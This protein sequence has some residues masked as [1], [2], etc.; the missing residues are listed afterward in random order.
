VLQG[1]TN[2][3]IFPA[4]T[5]IH[6]TD[7]KTKAQRQGSFPRAVHAV[8]GRGG[9]CLFQYILFLFHVLLSEGTVLF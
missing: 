8:R 2:L 5:A 4:P 3:C 7:G 9:V 1:N 6:C